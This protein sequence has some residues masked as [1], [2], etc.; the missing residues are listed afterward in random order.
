MMKQYSDLEYLRLSKWQKFL[1]KIVSFFCAIPRA[2]GHFFK[3]IGGYI[4]KPL[5]PWW[6]SSAISA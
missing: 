3:N 5:W 1:Y 2:I 4:K 6:V